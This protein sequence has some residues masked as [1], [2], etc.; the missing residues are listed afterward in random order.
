MF[1]L[2]DMDWDRKSVRVGALAKAIIDAGADD[3]KVKKALFA[4]LK[5]ENVILVKYV[6]EALDVEGG[7]RLHSVHELYRMVTS[8]VYPGTYITLPNF[9]AWIDWLASS[10]HIKLV[11]IR[12]ALSDL[13]IAVIPELRGIDVEEILE[14]MAEDEADAED[15]EDDLL[16]GVSAPVA[17]PPPVARAERDPEDDDEE[18]FDDLPPEAPAPSAAAIAKAAAAFEST[19]DTPLAALAPDAAPLPASTAPSAPRAHTPLATAHAPA[20]ARALST[21]R[22]ADAQV[23]QAIAHY[24]ELGDWPSWTA[25]AL[26]VVAPKSAAD[27]LLLELGVLAAL[28]EGLAP[29]P[30]V[31]AFAKRLR[32]AGFFDALAGE[33]GF[34]AALTALGDLDSEPWVRA[35]ASRLMAAHGIQARLS[36]KPGLLKRVRA[37]KSGAAAVASLRAE[38]FGNAGDE[39]PFW[40]LRELVRLGVLSADS[41]GDAV[42][43][44]TVALVR[45]AY[46]L[47]L[48]SQPEI[49]SFE[50]LVAVSAAVSAQFGAEAGYGEALANLDRGLGLS[51]R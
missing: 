11:G 1:S 33:G 43:V 28:V 46:R 4:R 8:Y 50:E 44:P 24:K 49:A 17:A 25:P 38:L 12:W 22:A 39:A 18:A 20:P 2:I 47:G 51:E 10:G 45:N 42:A 36:A 40:V 6:L 26:G 34:G 14:D 23:A 37:T 9:Q 32:A 27:A 5:R 31:F 21:S 16:A 29:Q 15:E 30:Q 19:F 35:L 7:G 3:E 48:V 13:G 41:F